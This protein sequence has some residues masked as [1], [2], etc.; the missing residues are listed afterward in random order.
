M[1]GV[2]AQLSVNAIIL[3]MR[4]HVFTM[5]ENGGGKMSPTK[6]SKRGIQ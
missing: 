6:E 4:A 1:G 5:E 3:K 2:P